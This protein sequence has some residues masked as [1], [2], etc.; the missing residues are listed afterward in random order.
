[1]ETIHVAATVRN[2]AVPERCWE[3][4]FLV[5]TGATDTLVPRRHLEAIGI[6]PEMKSVHVLADGNKTTFDLGFARVE[7]MGEFTGGKVIFGDDDAQP[8]LGVT[9]LES[10]GILPDPRSREPKKLSAIPRLHMTDGT[11]R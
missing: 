10:A 3:G 1:M 4:E 7:F 2:P 5:D 11:W 8:L 9:A 6:E